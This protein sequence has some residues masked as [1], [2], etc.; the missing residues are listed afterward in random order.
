M[1]FQCCWSLI[2]L[3]GLCFQFNFKHFFLSLCV[4]LS[5]RPSF[6]FLFFIFYT[7]KDIGLCGEI[8]CVQYFYFFGIYFNLKSYILSEYSCF[9]IS[10]HSCYHRKN[11]RKPLLCFWCLKKIHAFKEIKIPTLEKVYNLTQIK[12]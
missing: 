2:F 8:N 11:D 10:Q 1:S 3:S 6:P 9:F 4:S 5:H 12:L 7:N